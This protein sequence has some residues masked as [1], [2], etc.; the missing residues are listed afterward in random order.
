[1]YLKQVEM[2]GFKSF[3]D[4][5]E[6]QLEPGITAV[7]GPNGSGKS[8]ISDAIQWVLGEQS[9]KSLRGARMEDIIFT[10]SV[11]RRQLGIAE[12]SLTLD[13]TDGMLPIDYGEVNIMRRLYRSGESEYLLNKT[14]CRLKDIQDLLSDTGLGKDAY[15][16]VGQGKIDEILSVRSEDRRV[17]LEEAAGITKYKNRKKEALRRLEDTRQNMVRLSD[18]ITELEGQVGPLA[19]QAEKAEKYAALHSRLQELEVAALV[20]DLL[21]REQ[22]AA[23]VRSL[24]QALQDNITE[25]TATL[26]LREAEIE[27][28][29]AELAGLDTQLGQM[30]QELHE[31][32]GNR[33][34][35][36]GQSA[37]ARERRKSLEEQQARLTADRSELERKAAAAAANLA[38]G[39]QELERLLADVAGQEA[40]IERENDETSAALNRLQAKEELLDRYKGDLIELM[41]RAA[42]GQ[43]KLTAWQAEA[44]GIRRTQARL[45]DEAERGAGRRSGIVAQLAAKEQEKSVAARTA[46]EAATKLQEGRAEK[47]RLDQ[48]ADRLLTRAGSLRDEMN[49]LAARHRA[50]SDMQTEYEG[51]Q[52]GVRSVLL[53]VRQGRLARAGIR[54]VLSELIR[55]PAEYET[56]VSTALGGAMQ[57]IVTSDTGS[58]Q[59]AIEYLKQQQGGRATFLPMN[60]I[61]PSAVPAYLQAVGKM[62]GIVGLAAGLVETD[63]AYQSIL[64]YLLGHVL[65][66]DNLDNALAAAAKTGYRSRIVTLDGELISPGGSISGGSYGRQ[67]VSL[68]ARGREI[69]ALEKT[70]AARKAELAAMEADGRINSAA[71]AAAQTAISNLEQII[72]QAE[73]EQAAA[74]REM[75]QL[76]AELAR[77]E[78]EDKLLQYDQGAQAARLAD[79]AAVAAAQQ[80][81]VN[82]AAAAVAEMQQ[83]ISALQAEISADRLVRD[84]LTRKLTE[85]RVKLAAW[86]QK[87]E[88]IRERVELYRNEQADIA[89]AIQETAANMAALTTK[90]GETDAAMAVLDGQQAEVEQARGL[91]D[92]ELKSRRQERQTKEAELQEQEKQ[93][94]KLSRAITEGQNQLHVYDLR[95]TTLEL[96]IRKGKENLLDDYNLSYEAAKLVRQQAGDLTGAAATVDVLREEIAALGQINPGAVGEYARIRERYDFLR[97]QY[98]DLDTAEAG[99]RRVIAEMDTVMEKLFREAFGAIRIH[100]GEIFAVLFEGGKADLHLTDE[101]NFWD[102]GVEIF[103]QPPGKKLQHLSLLS[104]GEKALTAISLLF[105]ILRYRPS[106]FCVLDEID[107]PLDEA[108]VDRFAAFL[109]EF[110]LRTQFIVVT[111]R[112]GTMEAADI[113]YGVTMEESGVSKLISVKFMEEAS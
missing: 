85:N 10:G 55:V 3:A 59:T 11:T 35:I 20:A 43:N 75:E 97:R 88:N 56:A 107:A 92:A 90:L 78:K 47:Q 58:A 83:Q 110:A 24:L 72:Y 113:L 25:Q 18:I 53:A 54:G 48:E 15:S 74:I 73:I 51:Y 4:K 8:N 28:G 81:E 7:V 93:S 57:N 30:V 38:A 106:P 5:I 14:P 105:A 89:A 60:V 95:R 102:A 22:E 96:E 84:D 61:K 42:A 9:A 76:A 34:R 94:K 40:A 104:G 44:E 108:N 50:L 87:K 29:R 77:L 12:V 62:S 69:K 91:S 45:A 109:K 98:A 19:E 41:N 82:S 39:Q 16:I 65:V 64:E 21:E 68:L 1:M 86:Q 67:T 27:T 36:A 103:A 26:A 99:L 111:H 70:V 32:D 31:L 100:F 49:A 2:F 17:L 52:K 37:V 13:N 101:V 6:L 63:P 112:K 33:E 46:A 23:T 71:R 80:N 79:I 66:A